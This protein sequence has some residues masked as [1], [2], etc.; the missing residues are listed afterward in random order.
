M[1]FLTKAVEIVYD[2]LESLLNVVGKILGRLYN[3]HQQEGRAEVV[4]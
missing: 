4:G 3:E 1:N 2:V